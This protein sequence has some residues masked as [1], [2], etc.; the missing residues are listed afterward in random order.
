MSEV[1]D[2]TN[3]VVDGIDCFQ[4]TAETSLGPF[5]VEACAQVSKICY[6]AERNYDFEAKYNDMCSQNLLKGNNNVSVAE[7]I[8]NCAVKASY[9]VDAKLIIVFTNT[10]EAALRVRKFGPKCPILAVSGSI[11][12]FGSMLCTITRGIYHH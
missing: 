1:Q 7:S 8:A 2:I 3:A 10:G 11:N 4:L 6:E 5:Y 9:E 12:K